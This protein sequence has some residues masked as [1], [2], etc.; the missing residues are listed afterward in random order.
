M[1]TGKSLGIA[2]IKKGIKGKDL[3]NKLEVHP[4]QI[5]NWKRGQSM[6]EANLIALCEALDMPVSEFI[7]LGE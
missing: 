6:K 3:A 4:S 5:S 1:N 7:A 2:L